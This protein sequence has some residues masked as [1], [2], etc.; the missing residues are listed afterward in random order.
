MND[1]AAL[2]AALV[3]VKSIFQLRAVCAAMGLPTPI[4]T[5]LRLMVLG[6]AAGSGAASPRGTAPD[7]HISVA[8]APATVTA[9]ART[10]PGAGGVD[11]SRSH[12]AAIGGLN[13]CSSPSHGGRNS[14]EVQ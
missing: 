13:H 6:R 1:N 4:E 8:E 14:R 5:G 10:S 11:G 2:L 12:G 7:P 3:R 9:C